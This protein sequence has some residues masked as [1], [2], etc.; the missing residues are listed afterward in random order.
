MSRW[1][2]A[3]CVGCWNARHPDRPASADANGRT[4]AH[5]CCFCGQQTTSGIFIRE[6]PKT[7]ACAGVHVGEG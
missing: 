2:H 4:E 7:V 3:I 1:T 5:A 6:D